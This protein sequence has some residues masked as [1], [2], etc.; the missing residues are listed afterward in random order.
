MHMVQE[1]RE[2]HKSSLRHQNMGIFLLQVS[3][4]ISDKQGTM[5]NDIKSACAIQVYLKSPDNNGLSD[6]DLWVIIRT[7][8]VMV[9]Q[10]MFH[11]L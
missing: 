3:S 8:L 11:H 7:K 9:N 5:Y 2:I 1:F 10:K 4:R 6:L